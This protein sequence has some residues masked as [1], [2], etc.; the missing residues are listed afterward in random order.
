MGLHQAV[1]SPGIRRWRRDGGGWGAI[2]KPWAGGCH[3]L[4]T[5]VAPNPAR[6]S[7]EDAP[8]RC[9]PS[10]APRRDPRQRLWAGGAGEAGWAGTCQDRSGAAAAGAG[11]GERHLGTHERRRSAWHPV[12]G[13]MP[14]GCSE[15]A[16]LSPQPHTECNECS[17][18]SA[19]SP[20]FPPSHAQPVFPAPPMRESRP[21]PSPALPSPGPG[22]RG[23]LSS[24]GAVGQEARRAGAGSLGGIPPFQGP[25]H[26]PWGAGTPCITRL[27]TGAGG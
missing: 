3:P 7:R 15:W 12:P 19:R 21:Q 9:Q 6:A 26:H 13:T 20:P 18:L 23:P 24:P 8:G 25:C 10:S 16:V 22:T 14:D 17:V 4:Y 27:P 5:M 2:T 11:G 1:S